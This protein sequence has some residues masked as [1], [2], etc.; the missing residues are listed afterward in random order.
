LKTFSKIILISGLL[1]FNTYGIKAQTTNT[2]LNQVELMKQFVG[3]WK[4]EMGKDTI[5][6]GENTAFGNGLICNSQI[7]ARGKIINSI[8]QLFGYD[9]KIDKFIVA[10]LIESSPVIEMCEVWFTSKNKG[11]LII[12]NPANVALKYKFEFKTPDMIVQTALEGDKVIKDI[13]LTRVK[14]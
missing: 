13:T 11:E 5:I 7:I 10:E 4:S 8:K 1:L 9:K 6:T 12:T 14:E 3:S 2:K